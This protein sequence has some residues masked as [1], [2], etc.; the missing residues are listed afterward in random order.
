MTVVK[1]PLVYLCI[2]LIEL[3]RVYLLHPKLRLDFKL[4]L[5]SWIRI[6]GARRRRIQK[7]VYIYVCMTRIG[8]L[9]SEYPEGHETH[10][11]VLGL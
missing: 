1:Y 7:V 8:D 10:H 5:R 4:R 11:W 3:I 2:S 9:V 6:K